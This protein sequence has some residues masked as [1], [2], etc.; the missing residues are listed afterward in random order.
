[1][2]VSTSPNSE[3]SSARPPIR[4]ALVDDHTMLRAGTRRLLEDESDVVVV[5]EA[6][7]GAEGNAMGND[8]TPTPAMADDEAHGWDVLATEIAFQQRVTGVRDR[9]RTPCGAE[10][11]YVWIAGSD[12]AATLALTDDDAVVLTRQYRHPLRRVILDLP[13]GGVHPDETPAEAARRE[14]REETGYLADDLRLLGRFY[15]VPGLLSYTVHVFVARVHPGGAPAYDE[16]EIVE[17][18]TTPWADLLR[19]VVGD[20]A[21]A[22][23]EPV[24]VTLAYAVLRY[25]A[26]RKA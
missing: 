11:D 8:Q 13:A 19:R 24:D 16:R 4:V 17:V 7:D 3:P 21:S 1:M 25:A 9:L 22:A 14:L 23:D 12:A 2:M 15:P 18:V 6:G 5:G 20:P 26:Q 10:M